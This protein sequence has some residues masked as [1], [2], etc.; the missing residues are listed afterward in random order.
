MSR[1]AR[2]L[3]VEYLLVDVPASTPLTPQFTFY[4]NN[5]ITPFP[6]E[7][8][9]VKINNEILHFININFIEL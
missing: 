1:L 8:R 7:N 9:Y 5:I 6:I 2:P 4:I 3:P